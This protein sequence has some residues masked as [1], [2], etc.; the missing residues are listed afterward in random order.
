M[1]SDELPFAVLTRTLDADELMKCG[2]SF[3]SES[4]SRASCKAHR[5]L[6]GIQRLSSVSVSFVL[7]GTDRFSWSYTVPTGH[8]SDPGRNISLRLMARTHFSRYTTIRPTRLAVCQWVCS[9]LRWPLVREYDNSLIPS[10]L[11]T[12]CPNF[13][14]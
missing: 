4:T 7:V 3:H 5:D 12:P 9:N 14:G 6:D 8:Y 1:G 11:V 2:Y 13:V 10:T